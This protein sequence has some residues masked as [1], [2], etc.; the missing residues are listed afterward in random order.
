MLA[1]NNV[2]TELAVLRPDAFL[3]VKDG[4]YEIRE[5][6]MCPKYCVTTP[7]LMVYLKSY[8]VKLIYV[9]KHKNVFGEHIF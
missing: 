4:G 6:D 2:P 8:Q 5:L 9:S 1:T 7:P 3:I